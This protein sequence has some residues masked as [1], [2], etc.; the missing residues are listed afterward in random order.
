MHSLSYHVALDSLVPHGEFILHSYRQ[1]AIGR[2]EAV[3]LLTADVGMK[4]PRVSGYHVRKLGA[5]R[6]VTFRKT[7][8]CRGDPGDRLAPLRVVREQDD[9]GLLG[10]GHLRGTNR[11]EEQLLFL[12]VMAPVHEDPEELDRLREIAGVQRLAR[13]GAPLRGVHDAEHSANAHVLGS[14]V[15][16]S[17]HLVHLA[18]RAVDTCAPHMPRW[19]G[20]TDFPAP[21]QWV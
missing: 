15:C 1:L 4:K 21:S 10:R 11:R 7:L 3:V 16:C 18:V 14:H 9:D 20:L 17:A 2:I 6:L 5:R 19:V 12:G 13:P 8:R